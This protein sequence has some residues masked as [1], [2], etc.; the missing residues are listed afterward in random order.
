M[1]TFVSSKWHS[2]YPSMSFA[3][4][5]DTGSAVVEV[6][7]LSEVATITGKTVDELKTE[8]ELIQN[9][10][11]EPAPQGEMYPVR[12]FPV[13]SNLGTVEVCTWH[14]LWLLI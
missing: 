8:L 1:I 5:E 4:L 13:V 10:L 2:T 3:V 9:P 7:Q 6:V 12:W 14:D 11:N